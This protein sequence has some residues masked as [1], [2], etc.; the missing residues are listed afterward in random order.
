MIRDLARLVLAGLAVVVA[1]GTYGVFR[2]WDQGR[3][4]G[5]RP[6]G[7]VVVLGAAQYDGSPSPVF[8]AR[9]D[10]AVDEFL[11]GDYG[12]LVV[13][14]GKAK[15]DRTTEAAV[16]RR[17]AIARG[18]PADRILVEDR[19]RTT[20]ESM[21]AVARI[22][23]EHGIED[24]VFVS[25]PTHMLRILRMAH[26]LGI[27][28]WGSPTTTSPV[29]SDPNRL[30]RAYAHELGALALYLTIGGVPPRELAE[31]RR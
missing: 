13:T 18:V 30:A 27:E 10:H 7:A 29:A 8:A 19:G 23:A 31:P 3:V 17:S 21:E 11:T 28:A 9:I 14:G 26:D 4:E 22:L 16:A 5:R 12:Y 20:L 24:A 6:A 25:D 1:V 2:I 15:G